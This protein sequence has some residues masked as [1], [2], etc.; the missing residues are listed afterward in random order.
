MG[1]RTFV[2]IEK[3]IE[4]A[5]KIIKAGGLVIYPTET[6]YGLAADV[7]N[8]IAVL[9]V[10]AA[11]RRPLDN[12]LSVA[13]KDLNQADTLAYINRY[14]R[15][16]A[17]AFLPGPLTIILKKKALL[18]KELTAGTDKIGIRIPSHP[19]AL[20]LIELAGPI[21]ATSANISGEPAPKTTYDAKK[22]L[23]ERVNFILD[24]GECKIGEPSTVVDVSVDEEY[25]I[26]R[27]GSISRHEIKE[28]LMGR[29]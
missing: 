6:V 8:R 27:T 12:P 28:A 15:K 29:K 7:S 3:K 14:A 10:F 4:E 21:T 17:K 19:I 11:K 18:P 26:L 22:Q 23:G 9:K 1:K 13:V 24:G 20:K 25:E 2:P 16:L 5:A